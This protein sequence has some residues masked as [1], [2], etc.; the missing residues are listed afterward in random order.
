MRYL[1]A[2]L[3]A[4]AQIA[5]GLALVHF[6]FAAL[7]NGLLAHYF[8]YVALVAGISGPIMEARK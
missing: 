2:Y 5:A 7:S 6:V 3:K 4:V 1:K 8:I